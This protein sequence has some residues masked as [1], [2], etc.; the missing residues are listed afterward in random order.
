MHSA[1]YTAIIGSTL[2]T[3]KL[4][5]SI[6][7]PGQDHCR[8]HCNQRVPNSKLLIF[9]SHPP[10]LNRRPADYESWEVRFSGSLLFAQ[11]CAKRL[12]GA[13]LE[14]VGLVHDCSRAITKLNPSPCESPCSSHHCFLRAGAL[15]L[16]SARCAA[17]ALK[18]PAQEKRQ[19]Y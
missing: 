17:P 2:A 13:R 4:A 11:E 3:Q 9:W 1:T 18:N 15:L 8:N 10:G 7:N 16:T 14:H 12:S 19:S 5:E 6:T